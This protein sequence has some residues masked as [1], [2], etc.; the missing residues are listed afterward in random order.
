MSE[1]VMVVG[2]DAFDQFQCKC[3]RERLEFQEMGS[4]RVCQKAKVF[5]DC[6]SVQRGWL[7]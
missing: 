3:F 2:E 1:E 7:E 5:E 6:V 4:F